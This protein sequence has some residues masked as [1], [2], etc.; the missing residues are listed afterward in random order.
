MDV[1]VTELFRWGWGW[2]GG[3]SEGPEMTK[4]RLR[5]SFVPPM[6]KGKFRRG[7]R[8]APKVVQNAE[9]FFF[10]QKSRGPLN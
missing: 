1:T 4:W 10:K 3:G 2:V 8:Q 6:V 7:S 9:K 5:I